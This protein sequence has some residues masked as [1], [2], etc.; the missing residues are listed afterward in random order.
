MT[1]LSF[2]D[3]HSLYLIICG[4]NGFLEFFMDKISSK[5]SFHSLIL[6][7]PRIF[8]AI[9]SAVFFLPMLGSYPVLGQW[10]PHYGRVAMEMMANGSWDWFLDPIYL[11]KHNFWSKP[12]FCF[13]MVFPFMKVLGPTELALRLP[14]AINGIFFV[15]LVHFIAEKILKDPLKALIAGFVTIFTPY[16]YMISRQFMWDITFVTFL[17]ASIGF[18][19][20]GQ[21]D[22][23]KKLIRF[24]YLFMGLGMLTKG[25]LAVCFPVAAMILWMLATLDYS[26]GFKAVCKDALEF[27]I[28]LRPFEGAAIFLVVSLPWYIYMGVK[29]GAPFYNEFFMEHHFGR[30]GGTI[31]KP[32]GPF[33]FYIWQ[34]SL[35]AFPW[36]AF[37]IPALFSAAGKVRKNK[38]LAFV[39]LTFFFIFIFFTLSATKFPHYVFPVVPFMVMIL[40][41]GFVDLLKSER[42]A[43]VYPVI[44][45]VSALFL[46]LIGKDIATDF[47][48]A[49]IIY[50]ITTH[51]VQTWF[52]R[53]FDMIPYLAVFVPIMFICIIVPVFKPGKKIVFTVS[54]AVFALVAVAWSSY[55]NFYWVPHMLEVFTP[56][57][58]VEKYFEMKQPGDKI[59]DFDNWKNRS[60]HF[61]LGLDEQLHRYTK[62]DQI[63]ALIERNPNNT[64]FITTKKDKVSEL[65]A[66]LLDKPG[67]PITKVADDAVD[68]Y[69]EIEMFTASMKDKNADLS[70]KWKK[71][72]LEESQIPGGIKKINGTLGGKTIE[73]IGYEINKQ[74]FDPGEEI[75]LTV[76]YK[77]LKEMNKNWKVFFH[78]DVYNGALPHSFKLDDYPQQGYLP[79]TKWTQGMILKDTFK[80]IVPREH[81]G[82]GVKIYTGFYEGN[83]RMAVD[84]DSLNDG[85]KR[86]ILGTF[87]VNIK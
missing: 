60:M 61:Y 22:K 59:V 43:K 77:V 58:L 54:A 52:G 27:A 10:E 25:L 11:G 49:D 63:Q 68:T 80:V 78:F 42:V 17:T 72:L 24:S 74:R 13:W 55:I 84:K 8:L 20:I 40:A 4:F 56:K 85:Q 29:H 41:E 83:T 7:H 66:A 34:L 76:Y 53:V 2:F 39:L 69:M 47:N 1:K 62:V 51:H 57:H 9:L 5:S 35:G 3:L 44:G 21:R 16:T 28:S 71:N 48:Y 86:F 79:T 31:D 18:L 70:D 65:R 64:V 14:F 26:K 67:I 46:V 6:D 15:L 32:D 73:I 12:I 82:G 36:V 33:E 75:E 50:I 19:Y 81:P 38:D 87:N 30:L 23:D 45:V 37:L